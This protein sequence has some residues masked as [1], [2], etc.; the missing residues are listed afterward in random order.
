MQRVKNIENIIG[1]LNQILPFD[2]Q[3]L[4]SCYDFNAEGKK[5]KQYFSSHI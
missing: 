1:F 2:Q 4:D 3:N 5:Q